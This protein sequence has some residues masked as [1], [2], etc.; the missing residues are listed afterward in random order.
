MRLPLPRSILAWSPFSY[1]SRFIFFLVISV[2]GL[3]SHA[4]LAQAPQSPEA[5]MKNMLSAIE[6]GSL[7][8]FVTS[9]DPAF[10][11]GMTQQIFDSV[12]QSLAPRIKQGYTAKYLTSLN[13]QGFIV[14]LWKLEFKDKND[15]VLAT[16]ALKD[17]KVSGFW[18]R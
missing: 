9:G 18:L 13:Q 8:D 6:S 4:V 15:D 17:G 1:R 2:L 3:P 11:S 12:R 10:R 16:L 7:T 5:I 14:Y